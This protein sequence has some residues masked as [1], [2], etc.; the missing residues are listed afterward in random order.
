MSIDFLTNDES[1]GTK[2]LVGMSLIIGLFFMFFLLYDTQPYPSIKN[3]TIRWTEEEHRAYLAKQ[4]E[5]ATLKKGKT[6]IVSLIDEKTETELAQ[7]LKNFGLG[8]RITSKNR[9]KK[10]KDKSDEGVAEERTQA[11]T[12]KETVKKKKQGVQTGPIFKS[13]TD[14]SPKAVWGDDWLAVDLPGARVL[15]YNEMFSILQYRKY[16]AFRYKK[17]CKDLI[18]RA[19]EAGKK[20]Q[21]SNTPYFD[22]PTKLT[23]LRIGTK[24]M[25]R[26]ALPVVFKYFID[27]FKKDLPKD[28][29]IFEKES[30]KK[31]KDKKT[32]DKKTKDKKSKAESCSIIDDDNPNI[33]VEIESLQEKGDPRLAI[34]IEK[35]PLW[36]KSKVPT[37]DEWIEHKMPPKKAARK[38]KA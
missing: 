4:Q 25:D 14:C 28:G 22:G 32:K 31:T 36:S 37:W 18:Y 15:T 7:S 23:L 20:T 35:V 9:R 8:E 11:K 10:T 1:W 6:P 12:S 26:D 21:K 17:I 33:I 38:K 27:A 29:D 16:E 19:I 34:L 13:I 3:M 2:S 24:E 30:P 5:G